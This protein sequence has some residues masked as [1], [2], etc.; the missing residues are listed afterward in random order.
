MI[1]TKTP[2][3]V[4]FVGGGSDMAPFYEKYLHSQFPISL[5]CKIP[6]HTVDYLKAEATLHRH[7][8]KSRHI[9]CRR[10]R[11]DCRSLLAARISTG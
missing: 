7:P 11:R 9:W 8:D 4:S 10:D 2:F 5:Y 6:V 1:I 3:R